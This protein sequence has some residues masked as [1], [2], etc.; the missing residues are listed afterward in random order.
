MEQAERRPFC[1]VLRDRV[2]SLL[3]RNGVNLDP[4]LHPIWNLQLNNTSLHTPREIWIYMYK[5]TKMKDHAKITL[6]KHINEIFEH[7]S[8]G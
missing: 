5:A 2:L 8:Y 1:G 6:F 3:D 7:T 4:H